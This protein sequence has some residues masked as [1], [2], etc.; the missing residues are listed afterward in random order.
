M[1]STNKTTNYQLSQF[2]GTDKPAWLSDY[3]GD[4]GK[5]DAGVA[6]AQSTATGA[7]GKATANAT[8]IGTLSNLATEAKTNLVAAV[9]EVN[10]TASTALNTATTAAGNASQAKNATDDLKS[11]LAMTSF[12]DIDTSEVVASVGTVDHSWLKVAR[13]AD[14]TLGKIY[15]RIDYIA[16]STAF[17]LQTLT[18]NVDTG[19]R[20]ESDFDI[21]S[22]G[23]AQCM[24]GTTAQENI[25]VTI[26][27]K[28]TGKLVLTFYSRSA[29][30]KYGLIFLP[31]LYFIQDFGDTPAES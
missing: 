8:A 12:R 11:Y 4:M 31:C 15:G 24:D 18:V 3:N 19:L 9:N 14:G 28:T 10:T 21:I 22:A 16:S 1:S 17:A 27:V 7:D 29:S 6:A 2:I 25:Q 30:K 26:T 5:I 20:P 13:N 23:I